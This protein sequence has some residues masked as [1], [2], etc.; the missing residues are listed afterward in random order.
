M[1]RG[2]YFGLT[3]LTGFSRYFDVSTGDLG[4]LPFIDFNRL[5]LKRVVRAAP[6]VAGVSDNLVKA[7]AEKPVKFKVRAAITVRNKHK[8]DLKETFVKQAPKKSKPAVLKDW[9][10]KSNVKAERVNYSAE[11]MVDSNFGMPGAITVTNKHQKEFFMESITIEGFACGPV[12]FPC[13]S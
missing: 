13:N 1:Q 10:K 4:P 8:E 11:F 9:S 6:T 12:H 5:Q 3:H 7:A 2:L